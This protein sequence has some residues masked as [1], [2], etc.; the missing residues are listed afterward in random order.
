MDQRA[1]K[2]G[3]QKI[4]ADRVERRLRGLQANAVAV[5][6]EAK[7]ALAGAA[8]VGDADVHQA[9]GFFGRSAAGPGDSGDADAERGAGALANSVGERER[10]FGADGAF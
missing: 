9:D 1:S 8:L 5:A 4:A 10:H 6:G 2:R 3:E 7:G